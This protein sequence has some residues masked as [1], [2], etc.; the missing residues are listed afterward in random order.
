MKSTT[1]ALTALALAAG[2]ATAQAAPTRTASGTYNGM[3]W[4][5]QSTVVGQTSTGTI[6][7]GGNPIYTAP[8]PQYSGVVGLLMDYGA[9]GAF[10]C[11]GTLLADRQSILTAAHCVTDGP[12]LANPVST[13]AFFYGGSNPDTVVYAAPP[14]VTTVGVSQYFVNSG[15]TGQV[16]DQNDIAVLRLAAPAPAFA[17]AHQLSTVSDLTGA[18]YNIA[19]YGARSDAGGSVGANLGTG[20]LRQ[21]DNR[22]DYRWGDAAFGGFFDGFFDRAGLPSAQVEYSYVSDFDNGTAARDAS[23]L[24]AADFGLTGLKYNNLGTGQTEA[25]TAGGDSGGPQFIGGRIVSVTSYGLSFGSAYGDQDDLLNNSFGEMNGFVPVFIHA[26][27]IN[28]SMVP[29]PGTYG[30]MALGLLAVGM[31]ARRRRAAD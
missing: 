5:A 24:L 26:D 15:Y 4:E 16:I 20:R 9:A 13:T 25:S 21:G 14:G 11:S 12:T 28:A 10:V 1:L 31:A 2:L 23:G 7:S 8:M 29:E 17:N 18:G 6:A 27:F 30:L 3:T 19:G 22:F